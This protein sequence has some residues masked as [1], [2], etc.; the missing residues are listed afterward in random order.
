MFCVGAMCKQHETGFRLPSLCSRPRV[1]AENS[2][3]PKRFTLSCFSRLPW[4]VQYGQVVPPALGSCDH[5]MLRDIAQAR[6][7]LTARFY[8][9]M[10]GLLQYYACKLCD[11]PDGAYLSPPRGGGHSH[12]RSSLVSSRVNSQ[13]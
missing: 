2:P 13:G 7:F 6:A 8:T 3:V 1:T 12:E 11:S 4:L 5:P 9:A 10:I